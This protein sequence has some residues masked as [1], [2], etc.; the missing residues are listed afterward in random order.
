MAEEGATATR[1][2]ESC[3]GESC[4]G[5]SCL[6]ESPAGESPAGE[7]RPEPATDCRCNAV[8]ACCAE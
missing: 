7:S 2:G 1:P 4:L 5:E 6:G 3:L 8:L